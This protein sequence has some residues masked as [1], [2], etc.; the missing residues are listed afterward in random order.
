MPLAPIGPVPRRIPRGDGTDGREYRNRG[1]DRPPSP[2]G[3]EPGRVHDRVRAEHEQR[4]Q[5]GDPV[6]RIEE[7]RNE[8]GDRECRQPRMAIRI[9]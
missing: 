8:G 9:G 5:D 6:A 7:E 4:D 1:G 3:H 2:P